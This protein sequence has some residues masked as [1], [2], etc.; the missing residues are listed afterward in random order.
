MPIV[1][2]LYPRPV[3]CEL[4][5]FFCVDLFTCFVAEVL[6]DL[7]RCH[8]SLCSYLKITYYIRTIHGQF[9]HYS[10]TIDGQ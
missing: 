7:P 4:G 9:T 3:P 2:M 8:V 1:A 10:R 5:E 6:A